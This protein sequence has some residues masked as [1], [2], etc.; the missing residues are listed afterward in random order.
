[1]VAAMLTIEVPAI[2]L[3]KRLLSGRM[4]IEV[5]KGQVHLLAGPNGCGKSLLLDT[6]TGVYLD[7][8]IRVTVEDDDLTS[9][10]PHQRWHQGM[11]RMFQTP[12]LPS[13]LSAQQVFDRMLV[14][15]AMHESLE[16]DIL[17]CVQ[18][19]G[20][21]L[22]A[23][24]GEHS[25][26][27]RRIVELAIALAAERVVLLDEPFAGMPP[28]TSSEI[29]SLIRR[30]AAIGK[31]ILVIDHSGDRRLRL[32]DETTAWVSPAP[33][34]S[35][36][37]QEQL[38]PASLRS[39]VRQKGSTVCW[40]NVRVTLG[41]R[42]VLRNATIYLPPASLLAI[43]GGNGTGK[44]TLIR[45]MAGLTP[46][47]QGVVAEAQCDL[48]P[49]T[50]FLSPQPPKL[51]GEISVAD[52]LRLM[53]GGKRTEWRQ[54][55]AVRGGFLPYLGLG[56]LREQT[57]GDVLSGGESS[58]VALLGASMSSAQVLLLDEPFESLS[59]ESEKRAVLLVK[60]LLSVGRSIVIA[61]HGHSILEDL[62][63]A[64]VI[65]LSRSNAITGQ[66]AA[67]LFDEERGVFK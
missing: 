32:Y 62:P 42:S 15:P 6:V 36:S 37:C 52:N 66:W 28:N 18:R 8:T 63:P 24:L 14:I 54:S 41:D 33:V 30:T 22:A 7:R 2:K 50:V 31:R 1:M 23:P 11:R 20:V 10:S 27:Q 45:A 25:F 12:Q 65:S 49:G 3:G 19:T 44:S 35:A 16:K 40:N 64:A 13:E 58:L 51:V 48:A 4:H 26:G 55:E 67:S 21:R 5:D 34:R 61:T 29:S 43:T 56:S 46:L 47:W 17:A 57:R 60:M 9:R 39:D 53:Q 38:V 59:V